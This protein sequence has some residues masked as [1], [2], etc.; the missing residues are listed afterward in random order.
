MLVALIA[1]LSCFV[2]CGDQIVNNFEE[3][4]VTTD[5]YSNRMQVNIV[6]YSQAE[7]DSTTGNYKKLDDDKLIPI[8]G[9][10][11]VRGGLSVGYNEGERV[12]AITVLNQLAAL[13]K[14]TVGYSSTGTIESITMNKVKYT[15]DDVINTERKKTIE[16]GVDKIPTEV[17][18][19]DMIMWEWKVNGKVVANIDNLEIKEGDTIVLTLVIDNTT[20]G[21]NY[22]TVEEY[23]SKYGETTEA[24]E[25]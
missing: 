12:T 18:F 2:S 22:M 9:A 21:D 6:V 17:Y 24:T 1:V 15:V 16:I 20:E 5:P 19:R 13:R 3:E 10:P 8:I 4:E 11:E 14:G 23:N 7:K 25:A